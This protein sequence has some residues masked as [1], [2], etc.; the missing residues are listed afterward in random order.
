MSINNM[1]PFFSTVIM[2]LFTISVFQR[3]AV[4]RNPAFLYWG[5]GL[6]MFG[7]GSF[8]EA[9]LVLRWN[10][11]IFIVWYLF[12]A[13]LNAAWLGHGTLSL[14]VQKRW[15]HVLTALLVIG[16]VIA[17][18]LMLQ[19]TLNASAYESGVAISQTYRDIM[20]EGAKVRLTTPI[21][22]IYGLIM[23]VGG[24]LYSAFLFW[25]KRVLPNRVIGNVL[26][27]AG[28]LSIGF[29]SSLARMGYGEYLYIGELVAAVMM[30]GGF[31]MAAAPSEAPVKEVSQQ[32]VPTPA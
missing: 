30:Y 14:L 23:L 31:L 4:R 10:H 11:A 16:S 18:I 19:L 7:A 21:F 6:M 8:A 15:V 27:A 9:F 24:A 20:P 26:I 25:R 29:A 12:G 5:I 1:L 22:N 17:G 28:A 2:L 32:K 13:A 3:Y